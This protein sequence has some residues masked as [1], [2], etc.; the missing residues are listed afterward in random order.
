[1]NI[2]ITVGVFPPDIGGPA[3]FVPKISNFLI[4]NGHNIKIICLAEVENKHTEDKLDV[5]RIKRSNSLPIRWMKTIYQIVKN[6]KKSDLI[7]VNGLGVE[8]TIAN[9]LI[10]KQLIR[11]IVGDPVWERAYNQKRTT[12]SFDEFQNN[13]HSFLIEVQ[14]LLRNW[15]INSAE[16][17]ITPSDHLKN[18][19][20]GLGFSNKILK[21]NNGVD[22]TDIKKTNV[23]KADVNLLII[24]RLV[25]QKN[26]NIVIEAMELLDNKDL[27]L[28][29]IGE[30]GEF[31]KL[32]GVIHDLNLQNRVRLLGK[33]DNNKISQFLLTAD[34]FIQASD[35]EGLP[36]SVLEAINYEVPILSTEVG[37]CKDLLNDGERGF[38]IPVPPHKKI[39]AENIIFIIN[40]KDEA[41][42]RADAAKA[43]ISKEYNFLV[44][45][46]H[47]MEIFQQ[48]E[49][50]EV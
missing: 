30:G 31:S 6:G 44:Q 12:E 23:H 4:E 22:I 19:V 47:Y 8:S 27:K 26:I 38:I 37:G 20:S 43:F 39:I 17:V 34:I 45:A 3:S 32:E 15:S 35:Y 25:I 11:K 14:K 28:S 2:L 50:I 49:K 13:K 10:K 36:H 1:M 24:S 16:I 5:I 33:I 40:N 29:I 42:K 7:F 48:N 46:N 9:L 18:F 41:T 21:I